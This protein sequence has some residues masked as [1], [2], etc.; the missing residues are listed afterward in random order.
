MS[1]CCAFLIAIAAFPRI[2]LTFYEALGGRWNLPDGA[3]TA[4]R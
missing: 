1:G 4:T 3:R 2:G